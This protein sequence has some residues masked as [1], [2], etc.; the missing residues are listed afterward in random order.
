MAEEQPLFPVEQ[1][2]DD[3]FPVDIREA[4]PYSDAFLDDRAFYGTIAT[5]P[6]PGDEAFTDTIKRNKELI[7]SGRENII[8]RKA[9][10][11]RNKRAL[12]A[13][14]GIQNDLLFQPDSTELINLFET[15]RQDLERTDQVAAIEKEAIQNLQDFM[16]ED[17]YQAAIYT[18]RLQEGDTLDRSRDNATKLAIFQREQDKLQKSYDDLGI[19][20]KVGE[21]LISVIDMPLSAAGEVLNI[22]EAFVAGAERGLFTLPSDKIN[23]QA[24]TLWSSSTSVEE[25]DI[26]ISQASDIVR[27]NSGVIRDNK[28]LAVQDFASLKGLNNSD[29]LTYNVFTGL[30]VISLPG[31]GVIAKTVTT[32]V[33]TAKAVSN[34]AAAVRGAVDNV[35]KPSTDKVKNA[36]AI[37]ESIPNSLIP[38]HPGMID[39]TVG[40]SG[41]V[42]DKIKQLAR[43]K[44]QVIDIVTPERA[45][46]EQIAEAVAKKADELTNRFKDENIIDV[47]AI[48]P[49]SEGIPVSSVQSKFQ[50]EVDPSTR[51]RKL[52]MYLG[53]KTGDGGYLSE[54]A[55]RSGAVRRGFAVEDVQFHHNVDDRWYVKVTENVPENGIVAPALKETDFPIASRIGGWVKN[56]DNVTAQSFSEMRHLAE[57]AKSRMQSVIIKPLVRPIKKLKN[58]EIEDLGNILTLG[59]QQQKWFSNE[60][61]F[62]NYERMRGSGPNEKELLA[63]HAARELND[64]DWQVRNRQAYVTRARN[65]FET[66]QITDGGTFD[67]GRRNAK[68]ISP[69]AIQGKR[70]YDLE[71]KLSLPAGTADDQ[72][73]AKLDTG[74]YNVVKLEGVAE[75][76]GEK[77]KYIL[78]NKSSMTRGPLELEQLGY[79][80]GGHRLY[81]DKWFVKQADSI[82]FNDGTTGF[83]NPLTHIVAKTEKQARKWAEGMEQARLAYL[84]TVAGRM[85]LVEAERIISEGTSL[86][87]S[88]FEEMVRQR[89]INPD[90]EFEVLFDRTQPTAMTGVGKSRLW[91]DEF[92]NGTEQWH[93]TS[94]RMYYSPKGERL[95]NPFDEYAEIL[96]P[97]EALEQSINNALSTGAMSDYTTHVI[98]E[99]VRVASPNIKKG[100]FA[101]N[102]DPR[103]VFYDGAFDE[104][105]A[106]NNPSLHKTLEANR[107]VI[108]RFLGQQTSGMHGKEMAARR[109]AGWLETEGTVQKA[110]PETVRDWA[111]GKTMDMMSKN[112][113][114]AVRGLVFDTQLGF[115][116][117]GQFFLQTQTA[118][119]TVALDPVNGPGAAAMWPFIRLVG[120]N[121]S[122]NVL[123][124]VAKRSKIVHG[125]DIPEFKSMIRTMMKVGEYDLSGDI[126]ELGHWSNSVGGSAVSRGFRDFRQ[127]ARVIFNESEKLNRTVA[128]QLGWK[129]IRKTS[130]ELA[131]DS[132]E[133]VQAVKLRAADF[134][135]NMRHASS[136][137]WQKGAISIPTQFLSYQ[138]RLLEN[139]LPKVFGGNPRFSGQQKFRLAISQAFLYGT[140]GLP[141]LDYVGDQ[142]KQHRGEDLSPEQWRAVS[143]GFWDTMF[144]SLSGG[145]LDTDFSDRAGVGAGWSQTIEKLVSGDLNSVLSVVGGPT[146]SV[147]GDFFDTFNRIAL[148]S[149]AGIDGGFLTGEAFNLMINDLARNINSLDRAHKA[150]MILRYGKI[151]DKNGNP[152]VDATQVEALAAALGIPLREEREVYELLDQVY[153]RQQEVKDIAGVLAKI[154][155][156]FFRAMERGDEKAMDN[157][158]NLRAGILQS[159]ANDPLK[160][161]QIAKQALSIQSYSTDRMEFARQQYEKQL[162]KKVPTE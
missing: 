47:K 41:D 141:I 137:A 152:I 157:F 67:T 1:V 146:G 46:P 112:P 19:G 70:I 35:L 118:F 105:F 94:G 123:D 98:E 113:V 26:A 116:D 71:D 36:E 122:E 81:R 162:G 66:V 130:P 16:V 39:P 53:R 40:L 52:N 153:D 5:S 29:A 97:F 75:A 115:Y 18:S 93:N 59:E 9:E 92:Q 7:A 127:N 136:A 100:S 28:G 84:E 151:F 57:G 72:I 155:D 99:W 88:K 110:I 80:P 117:P 83:D 119:A 69:D 114:S 63:Y 31:A 56:P 73:K 159:Y 160:Q 140:A 120:T 145:N 68:I 44:E 77:V 74:N 64:F 78:A 22:E 37:A 33:R 106:R 91:V 111:A 79:T 96:D 58:K 2:S 62:F 24:R 147:T 21:F 10:T 154:N 109:I 76:D 17:P 87:Y 65:G 129:D 121:T 101:E 50:L 49:E 43:I 23:K 149:K 32:P 139:M 25:F 60:E 11:T 82:E 124:Y 134:A 143:Q 125:M 8:S 138:A 20:A 48:V 107:D 85:Q 128:W 131:M 12:E 161:Q 30:D 42:A 104:N 135:M 51:I 133:F 102:P 148:Y 89:K 132:P 15:N 90:H 54:E 126:I 108:K 150:S 156:D 158:G 14:F 13:N 61:L 103:R 142:W 4:N 3:L 6:V 144:F 34:R 86:N 95:K 38:D 45:S 55:A 27:Q